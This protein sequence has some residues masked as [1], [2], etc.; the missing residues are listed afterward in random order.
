M[1]YFVFR[2]DKQTFNDTTARLTFLWPLFSYWNNG[3]GHTQ[4]QAFDPLGT[5]FPNNIKV[6]ENWTPLFAV[7]RYD[8]RMGNR[9]HSVLWDLLVW[10][11]DPSGLNAFYLGPVFEWVKDDHWEL[12]K[13]LIGSD[14][15]DDG[16]TMRY[17][18]RR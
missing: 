16:R 17:F 7:Y 2:D 8:N 10:E 15:S 14:K 3:Y 11:R 13:G 5:F 18:W 6:K 12:L 4:L 1:L 9:R